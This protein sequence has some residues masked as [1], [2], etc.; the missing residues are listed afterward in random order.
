MLPKGFLQTK[1]DIK[2]GYHNSHFTM[3]ELSKS[4]I[5]ANERIR[6]IDTELETLIREFKYSTYL[7]IY[8]KFYLLCD[9]IKS[10]L[11]N[12]KRD[13]S[14]EMLVN[15]FAL[16]VY[17]LQRLYRYRNYVKSYTQITKDIVQFQKDKLT[18]QALSFY[19]IR[20][21]I[22]LRTE[23]LFDSL[24]KKLNTSQRAL[25]KS[26]LDSSTTLDALTHTL[27]MVLPNKVRR[28]S[29]RVKVKQKSVKNK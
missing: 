2:Y 20:A 21:I 26:I 25:E 22:Q 6:F 9:K 1:I 17:R 19:Q 28:L 27:K 10:T 18:L 13:C 16:M 3:E 24:T 14:R 8:K 12:R 11:S 15:Q 29:F 23:C 4:L 7:K 5:S